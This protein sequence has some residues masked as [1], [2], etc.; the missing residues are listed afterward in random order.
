MSA[1]PRVPAGLLAAVVVCLAAFSITCGSSAPAPTQP[2]PPPPAPT[3]TPAAVSTPRITGC[4]VGKGPGAGQSCPRTSASFL[5]AVDEAINA[6]G[7][8]QPGLFDFNDIHGREGWYVRDIDAYYVAVVRELEEM[9]Y[10]AMVDRGNE[11][12]VKKTNDLSDQYHIMISSRHVRRDDASYR[13]T[14]A[15]AWF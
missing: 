5:G 14:C 9:G 4:G 12:A 15:P 2:E 6:V 8:K 7:R 3:P 11:I 13:A 10:C 1:R